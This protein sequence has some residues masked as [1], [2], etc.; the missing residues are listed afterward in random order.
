MG[1]SDK[2]PEMLNRDENIRKIKAALNA[3][4]LGL[5]PYLSSADFDL[6]AGQFG[7]VN[8]LWVLSS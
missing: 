6:L 3:P 4:L 8:R 1:I 2:C 7:V 5:L